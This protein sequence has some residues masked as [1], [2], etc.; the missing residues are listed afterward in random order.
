MA[1]DTPAVQVAGPA[2]LALVD[3]V[4]DA[5]EKLWEQA[6]EVPVDDRTLFALAVSEVLTNMVQHSDGPCE[7]SVS[8]EL[9]ATDDDLTAILVDTAPPAAIDWHGVAMPDTDSESGRGLALARAA[10]DEFTHTFDEGGNRWLLRRR[11]GV[12]P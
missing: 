12:R 11:L 1:A 4:H 2:R 5:L 10:L 8:V 7:V 6:R 9:R 3:R